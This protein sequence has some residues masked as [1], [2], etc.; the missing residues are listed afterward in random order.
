MEGPGYERIEE[1]MCTEFTDKH[2]GVEK[3]RY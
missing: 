2:A 1:W 3:E